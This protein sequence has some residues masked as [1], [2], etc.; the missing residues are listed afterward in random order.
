[1]RIKRRE[2]AASYAREYRVK[3]RAKYLVA[4]CRRRCLKRGWKFDL[5]NHVEE[6]QT[7]MNVGLCEL[8]GITMNMKPT[9]GRPF[10]APSIDRIDPKKGY[11]YS[12]IRIIC[13]AANAMLGDWGEDVALKMAKSWIAKMES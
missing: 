11:V 9:K 8:T 7:R 12:N 3:N 4:E 5:N 6:I 10:N 13:F 1:M 2:K